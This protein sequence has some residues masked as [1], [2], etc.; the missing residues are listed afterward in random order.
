MKALFA[1]LIVVLGVSVPAQA[2]YHYATT[3]RFSGSYLSQEYDTGVVITRVSSHTHWNVHDPSTVVTVQRGVY[4]LFPSGH[5]TARLTV[6]QSGFQTVCT[7]TPQP[8][9]DTLVRQPNHAW[10][11]LKPTSRG[12]RIGFGW[13]GEQVDRHNAAVTET[14]CTQPGGTEV[15]GGNTDEAG[16]TGMLT[17]FGVKLLLNRKKLLHGRSIVKRVKVSKTH[18]DLVD[19]TGVVETFT[20][21]YTIVLSRVS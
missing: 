15:A 17:R 5:T 12:G 8:F 1:A 16:A 6:S 7:A 18:T 11:T 20:G 4:A 21:T 10:F 9:G 13:G 14:D 2:S 3:I 19:G